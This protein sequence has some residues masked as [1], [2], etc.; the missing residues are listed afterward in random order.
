[1]LVLLKSVH[2][3]S[4]RFYSLYD[5]ESRDKLLE[6]YSDTVSTM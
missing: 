2:L 5:G 3:F 6:A 1:M 4:Y